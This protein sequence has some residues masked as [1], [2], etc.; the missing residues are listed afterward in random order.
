M[1]SDLASGGEKTPSCEKKKTLKDSYKT[2]FCSMNNSLKLKYFYD[3]K[4]TK[5]K[6]LFVWL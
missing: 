1:T 4:E 6:Q 2:P 3:V 5:L